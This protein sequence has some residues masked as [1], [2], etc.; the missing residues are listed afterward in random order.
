MAYHQKFCTTCG[1]NSACRKIQVQVDKTTIPPNAELPPD[2]D[3]DIDAFGKDADDN[4]LTN[5]CQPSNSTLEHSTNKTNR[6]NQHFSWAYKEWLSYGSWTK[7]T[8]RWPTHKY[9]SSKQSENNKL[10]SKRNSSEDALHSE[11]IK[12]DSENI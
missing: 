5:Q 12:T 1:W 6:G 4:E 7:K 10:I 3:A 8:S 2:F 11:K 9:H